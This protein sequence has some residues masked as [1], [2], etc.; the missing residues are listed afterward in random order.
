[1]LLLP[2]K[3]LQIVEDLPG[4]FSTLQLALIK[5]G[6]GEDIDKSHHEGG[7]L[8]APSNT[9]FQKLGV[10]INHFLFS[11]PGLKYLKALLKYHIVANQTLY[12][13]AFYGPS[14]GKEASTTGHLHFDLPTL[15]KD[16][17]LSV[18]I[19]T[20]GAFATIKIN[21]F[22]TVTVADGVASDGV[23][24]VVSN[25]LIPPRT[26]GD[27]TE[28]FFEEMDLEEFKQRLIPTD[29]AQEL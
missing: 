19:G 12:T 16:K 4:E 27:R 1:V 25:V 11:K 15:L 29:F 28:T 8:F 7:T 2:P 9:A 20:W 3:A 10:R 14:H 21:A 23:I 26:P 18:D 6:L 17:N 22:S 24:Q 5:T 13:D